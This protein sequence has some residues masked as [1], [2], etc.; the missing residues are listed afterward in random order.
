LRFSAYT[1]AAGLPSNSTSRETCPAVLL[2]WR[3]AGKVAWLR[4]IFLGLGFGGL[5]DLLQKWEA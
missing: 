3:S 5:L 4:S 1:W 2:G